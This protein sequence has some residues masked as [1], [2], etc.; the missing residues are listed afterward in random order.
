M[1]TQLPYVDLA[2]LVEG[3]DLPPHL[4][5]LLRSNEYESLDELRSDIISA[6]ESE[7]EAIWDK[8]DRCALMRCLV[9]YK[10][11]DGRVSKVG[12]KVVGMLA[13]DLGVSGQTIRRYINLGLYYPPMVEQ[14]NEDGEV[15]TILV[16]DPAVPINVY[17]AGLLALDHGLQPL[18]AVLTAINSTPPMTAGQLRQWIRQQS[19]RESGEIPPLSR[20]WYMQQISGDQPDPLIRETFDEA[21][22]TA[23]AEIKRLRGK[24]LAPL[25]VTIRIT[26]LEP[27]V[28]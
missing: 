12:R 4:V 27:V 9:P 2:E 26:A 18:E 15:T 25:T 6:D 5:A 22:S 3:A 20:E 13:S 21:Y 14:V 10:T 19:Y 8:A 28:E 16:R 24:G 11:P 1:D 7:R 17:Q 23:L